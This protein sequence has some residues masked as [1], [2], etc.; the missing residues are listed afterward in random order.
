MRC[1]RKGRASGSS[2]AATHSASTARAKPAAGSTPSASPSQITG[3]NRLPVKVVNGSPVYLGEVAPATFTHM[4]QSNIVRID[5]KT[6][7]LVQKIAIAGGN[8]HSVA[9]SETNGHVFVP[10][11]AQNNG[12]GCIQ[13]Y[14]PQ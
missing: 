2:P 3:F 13:V 4:V 9:S 14:G 1:G 12:C 7:K 11:G 5:A 6:N 8:P 10:V